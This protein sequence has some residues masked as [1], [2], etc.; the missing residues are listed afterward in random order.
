MAKPWHLIPYGARESALLHLDIEAADSA[1]QVRFVHFDDPC[2]CTLRADALRSAA[3]AL[4]NLTPYP[5]EALVFATGECSL[6]PVVQLIDIGWENPNCDPMVDAWVCEDE[7][8]LDAPY[9]PSELRPLTIG[10]AEALKI[11][12]N[13]KP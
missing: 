2:P 8:G 6:D 12:G 4:R 5:D 3:E 11:L 10:A 9:H 1:C 13:R 7:D